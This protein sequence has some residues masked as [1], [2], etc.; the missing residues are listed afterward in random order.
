VGW[1][2]VAGK[3]LIGKVRFVPEAVAGSAEEVEGAG[4]PGVLRVFFLTVL[5]CGLAKMAS[6]VAIWLLSFVG[7]AT[8]GWWEDSAPYLPTGVGPVVADGLAV[9]FVASLAVTVTR[10]VLSSWVA[11]EDVPAWTWTAVTLVPAAVLAAASPAVTS[12]GAWAIAGVAL[13]Y[14]AWR[15][16]GRARLELRF[17]RRTDG[18]A[19]PESW[20]TARVA[21]RWAV[22]VPA[23]LLAG[24]SG[25]AVFHPLSVDETERAVI[26]AGRS[27][28]LVQGPPIRNESG[29]AVRVLSIEPGRERGYAL[30]LIGVRKTMDGMSPDGVHP[31]T[32]EVTSF[33]IRGNDATMGLLLQL[34]RAG[35]RPG[36][37]GR[38]ETVRVRYLRGGEHVMEL[39]LHPAPTLVC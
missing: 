20:L 1:G 18:A 24:L 26:H 7:V 12:A 30:H 23:L 33:V 27:P 25:Y 17:A 39:P 21:R 6:G 9:L 34:S 32:R 19:R 11:E 3:S 22:V 38:I 29:R 13:R 5:A 8:T 16:D 15:S 14:V 2:S 4:R 28:V 10:A 35:C 31:P 37:S 36:T